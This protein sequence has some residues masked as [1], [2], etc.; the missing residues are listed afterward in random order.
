[1]KRN[2][3]VYCFY[4]SRPAELVATGYTLD[5]AQAICNDPETSWKTATKIRPEANGLPWFYGYHIE[6]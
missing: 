1:M 3:S 5:E 2:V 6:E 4:A